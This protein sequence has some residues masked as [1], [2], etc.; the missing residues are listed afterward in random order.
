MITIFFFRKQ[1]KTG[2]SMAKRPSNT[3]MAKT[4][5]EFLKTIKVIICSVYKITE[6]FVGGW[7]KTF[8]NVYTKYENSAFYSH[9]KK[10]NDLQKTW[11]F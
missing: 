5:D 8:W 6:S 9:L 10:S 7:N 3:I 2:N 4:T 11:H 1:T